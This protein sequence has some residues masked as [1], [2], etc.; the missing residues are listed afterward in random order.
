MY[1]ALTRDP[2]FI[3]ETCKTPNKFTEDMGKR[4]KCGKCGAEDIAP[5]KRF[6]TY[7]S[8]LWNVIGDLTHVDFRWDGY[9]LWHNDIGNHMVKNMMFTHLKCDRKFTVSHKRWEPIIKEPALFRCPKCATHPRPLKYARELFLCFRNVRDEGPAHGF[10]WDIFSP[11]GISLDQVKF[12]T[13]QEKSRM[14]EERRQ[15]LLHG[16]EE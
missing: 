6:F 1:E 11:I 2:I 7:Y 8:R 16:S 12:Y 10:V 9:D 3:C 4:L 14:I 13:W 15:R 5:P